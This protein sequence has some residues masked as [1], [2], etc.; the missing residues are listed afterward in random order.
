[1][2]ERRLKQAGEM[3]AFYAGCAGL[4]LLAFVIGYY[5]LTHWYPS[6]VQF[7]HHQLMKM[8]EPTEPAHFPF[9]D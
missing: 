5:T 6:K 7:L 8:G 2:V 9:L 3:V 4:G 1:M